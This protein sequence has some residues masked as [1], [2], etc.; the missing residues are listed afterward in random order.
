MLILF[1]AL[2]LILLNSLDLYDTNSYISS[3]TERDQKF[4]YLYN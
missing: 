4:E 2:A 3:Q 1:V